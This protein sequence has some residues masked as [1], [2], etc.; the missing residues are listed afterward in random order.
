MSKAKEDFPDPDS[1]V[2]TVISSFG[3]FT[4]RFLRLC[5]L[6]PMT[7]I[8]FFELLIDLFGKIF[9]VFKLK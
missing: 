5:S 7:L 9:P 3:I 8:Y 4:L 1:P 2:I 6:D